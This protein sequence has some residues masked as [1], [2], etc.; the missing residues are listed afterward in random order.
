[1]RQPLTCRSIAA[2]YVV[3]SHNNSIKNPHSA[4]ASGGNSIKTIDSFPENMAHTLY[5]ACVG[6]PDAQDQYWDL[7][8]NYE[9]SEIA[10]DYTAPI[11]TLAAYHIMSGDRDP[12]YTTLASGSYTPTSGLPCN[13]AYPCGE[14]GDGGG[15]GGG[16]SK[17][18]KI[19]IGVV[20]PMIVLAGI[21]V[22]V[23]LWER[24]KRRRY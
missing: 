7:R 14:D 5:G 17:A 22:G 24:K 1:M 13:D 3:G 9:R 4:P 21:F 8:G 12:F 11:L 16:L 15:G 6:G 23:W 20:V 10:V 18:A 2:V 19:A